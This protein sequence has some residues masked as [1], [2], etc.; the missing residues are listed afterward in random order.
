[1]CI[2]YL[3]QI[4]IW[5]SRISRAQELHVASSYGTGQCGSRRSRKPGPHP[6]LFV[7]GVREGRRVFGTCSEAR[8]RESCLGALG[9]RAGWSS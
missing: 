7:E 5:S 4:L 6:L 3:E 1:M 2:L 9:P 8:G